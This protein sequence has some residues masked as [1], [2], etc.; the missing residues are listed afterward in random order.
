MEEDKLEDMKRK[1]IIVRT[2]DQ[3]DIE[4]KI[5]KMDIELRQGRKRTM[6]ITGSK[7]MNPTGVEAQGQ[8]A[9]EGEEEQEVIEEIEDTAG[10]KEYEMNLHLL[11]R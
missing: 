9:E 10:R 3:E 1:N 5:E 6:M 7:T 11:R 4:D 8:E 2:I